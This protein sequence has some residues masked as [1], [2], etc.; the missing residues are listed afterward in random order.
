MSTNLEHAWKATQSLLEDI[1]PDLPP[2]LFDL[3]PIGIYV[4]D[5]DGRITR[6]NRGAAEM[7]GRE[8]RIG[9]D[10]EK[11]CG[12]HR[13]Y[14]MDGSVVPHDR[15]PMVEVL[16]GG[17]PVRNAEIIMERP[18]G[19]RI[20]ALAHIEP[21]KDEAG[22]IIGAVN[23]F[24]DITELRRSKATA[25]DAERQSRDIL[26]ALAAAV[27]TTDADGRITFYNE[28]AAELWGLR[29]ELGKSEFCGSWKLYWPDGTPLPHDQCPMAVALR[30][31]RPVRNTEAVAERPDGTRVPFMPFPTPLHD[32]FGEFVGA[33]NILVDIT[34]RKKADEA[35]ARQAREQS[36]LYRLTDGLYRAHSPQDVYNAALDAIVDG[37][38][39]ASASV[40][41][42]DEA[43]VMRFVAWRG[44]SE[45]YRKAVEGHTPWRPGQDD[46]QP[47]CVSD[48]KTVEELKPLAATLDAEGIRSLAFIPI[49]IDGG[50]IG[51]FMAYFDAPRAF[52]Q[53]ET[54]FS[55]TVARQLGFGIE[56]SRAEETRRQ[57]DQ[58]ARLLAAVVASSDDAIITKNLNS[59]ITSWN[60]GAE[61]LFGYSADEAIGRSVVML[62]PPERQDE[63]LVILDRI[64]SGQRIEH[65]ETV[66]QRKDGSLIDISLT[67][68]P[69][70]D[71]SGAI[72]GASKIA[73]DI[74]ER[75]RAQEQQQMLLREMDHRV[76][77]LFAVASGV[78]TL[79]ARAGSSAE[80]LASDVRDRLN[81]LS[82]AHALTLPSPA[83]DAAGDF[84][85]TTMHALVRT[86]V[87]P[88]EGD[89]T[90]V[91]ISG[92]DTPLKGSAVT[93]LALLFNEFA[94]NAAKYGSLSAFGGSVDIACS[95]SDD[96]LQIVWTE[97]GGPAVQ[98]SAK[99]EGF[100]SLL[101]EA[102]VRRQLGGELS[103]EWRADGLVIRLSAPRD[104]LTS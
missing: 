18:D 82:R 52:G 60:Q 25:R 37:L 34:D 35:L 45:S 48:V 66:R 90:R 50:V 21:L 29:P 81:A 98:A 1:A 85:A 33:V 27:Y 5:R 42:F 8:P 61:R 73:R 77:N 86:I 78:V 88:Y 44:L 13:L 104:R 94:T 11:Y 74:S 101:A 22:R 32:Q 63:E 4:C 19:E 99:G 83:S 23:C 67:V 6:H 51:K 26:N 30:E 53:H 9:D 54:E 14:R 24:R 69:V 39:C 59:I 93:S 80:T 97:R 102:T 89:E 100:G 36:A 68:S 12:S 79:S 40:L 56:R 28:T 10:S 20:V 70:K 16:A 46:A 87:A 76:K 58:A 2:K 17:P 7:W 103:R 57:S 31:R 55:L 72:V 91:S 65:Y 84:H 71:A 96:R 75:R 62:M 95:E 43:G 38:Q 49:T 41:L 92:V 64:R 15:S 47:I 3:L